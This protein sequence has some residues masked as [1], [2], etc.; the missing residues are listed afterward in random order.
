[1]ASEMRRAFFSVR[2]L[3]Q[4]AV[5]HCAP[6]RQGTSAPA[7][8]LGSSGILRS[9]LGREL[10]PFCTVQVSSNVPRAK[11][12]NVPAASPPYAKLSARILVLLPLQALEVAVP[13]HPNW[14]LSVT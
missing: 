3:L 7:R 4:A 5:R 11:V 8:P 1:M 14:M 10:S 13:S 6:L 12:F 9:P 2:I